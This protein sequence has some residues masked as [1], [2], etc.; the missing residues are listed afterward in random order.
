MILELLDDEQEEDRSRDGET[1]RER[2][3]NGEGQIVSIIIFLHSLFPCCLV[4]DFISR[5]YL[6][7]TGGVRLKGISVSSC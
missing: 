6:T 4:G 7:G 2:E 5:E 3:E 1:E